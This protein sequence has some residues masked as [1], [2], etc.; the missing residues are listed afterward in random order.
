MTK[1]IN[2]IWRGHVQEVMRQ[3][4]ALQLRQ[5]ALKGELYELERVIG[6]LN[7][8]LG[9]LVTPIAL[10][11]GFVEEQGPFSMSKDG[12]SIIGRDLEKKK[13]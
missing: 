8:H 6:Q 7:A 5:A 9:F 12:L 2:E 10:S 13:E 3:L 1:E 11:S 4:N